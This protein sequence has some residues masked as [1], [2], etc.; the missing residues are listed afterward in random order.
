MTSLTPDPLADG[1]ITQF[2]RQ[3]R[4]GRITCEQAT[5]AYL[6]RI[7][8]L[9]GRLN[10]FQ[11]V[12]ADS[13][14]AA[15]RAMDGLLASGT[16]LGPLMGVPVAIKDIFAVEGMPTTAGSHLDVSDLIGAEGRFVKSLKRAGCVILGKT[17]TVEFALGITGISTPQGTPWN[18]WDAR[19]QRLTGGSS[20]GSAVAAAAGLCAFAIGSDTG[21]SV[22]VPAA[23][24]GTFGLKTTFALWPVDGVF[25]LT[26]HL[27]TVGLL[28]KSAADASVA[29]S[30][31]CA[32]PAIVPKPLHGLR[33]GRP[34]GH[35]FRNLA[36]EVENR[37]R[38]AI[39]ALERAGAEIIDID[40]PEAAA[41]ERYFP[42][43][44]P[45]CLIAALGRERFLAAR[46]R[47]DPVVARRGDYGLEAMAVDFV[48]L[49]LERTALTR[50]ALERFQGLD[51]WISPTATVVPPPAAD[52]GD[53]ERGMEF[54]L[55][56]TQNSQPSNYL[57]LS[58][59]TLQIQGDA[60]SLPVGLQFMCPTGEDRRALSIALAVE[61]V[62]GP[63]K[64][65]PLE[66]FLEA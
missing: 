21:G 15:A 28:T 12:A 30:V 54:T 40:V 9:D 14:L 52:A 61:S 32:A 6:S 50:T 11:H 47:M 2:A 20:S 42:A 64:A 31:L 58:A 4:A 22:R 62:I 43:V 38:A 1:G 55:A 7:E 18:P 33:L 27:D 57:N 48:R 66:A 5:R 41:R 36:P 45:T 35:F 65:P 39:A 29:F 26:P 8:A 60:G 16:D 10:A 49:E 13:A 19:T 51:A 53:P 59:V 37:T 25:P 23:F 34:E 56:M 46:D 3:L 17:R 63:G 44:L 24:C